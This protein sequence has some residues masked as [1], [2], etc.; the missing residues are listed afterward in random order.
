MY[1]KS[2]RLIDSLS[3][4]FV[5]N[6]KFKIIGLAKK[7]KGACS[8]KDAFLE[9]C[10]LNTDYVYLEDKSIHWV[11]DNNRVLQFNNGQWRL[12]DYLIIKSMF[13]NLLHFFPECE[14]DYE[15]EEKIDCF[16]NTFRTLSQKNIG[17]LF[18]FLDESYALDNYDPNVELES[19]DAENLQLIPEEEI[20]KMLLN[21][22]DK[23]P[24]KLF[25]EVIRKTQD[26]N[27]MDK[28][29]LRLISDVDG[30]VIVNNQLNIIDYGKMIKTQ[31]ITTSYFKNFYL[32]H[33]KV[34]EDTIIAYDPSSQAHTKVNGGS[35]SLAAFN[36][37][38]FGGAIKVSEDGGI[39]IYHRR[40]LI[41]S[42]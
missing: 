1:P 13:K 31:D 21:K 38:T 6:E 15:K 10:P 18:T 7:Q 39:D 12:L 32:N 16:L 5:T 29:L 37:S 22:E 36:A 27:E 41:Y 26:I 33:Y 20:L 40:K 42:I 24:M 3:L 17:S 19:I 28:Y 25:K 8:I 11:V 23:Y 14:G 9:D 30:S 4:S 35:R 34:E 2:Y